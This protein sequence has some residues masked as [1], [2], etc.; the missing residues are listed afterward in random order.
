MALL[1]IEYTNAVTEVMEVRIETVSPGVRRF[2]ISSG[3]SGIIIRAPGFTGGY[4]F[5]PRK[6]LVLF[7][8]PLA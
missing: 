5:I 2:L 1:K 3:F 8:V 4:I 7:A 6:L